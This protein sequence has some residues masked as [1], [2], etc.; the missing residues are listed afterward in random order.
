MDSCSTSHQNDPRIN[1]IW[2]LPASYCGYSV[3]MRMKGKISTILNPDVSLSHCFKI[4]DMGIRFYCFPWLILCLAMGNKP[5]QLPK[6]FLVTDWDYSSFGC[7]L[8]QGLWLFFPWGTTWLQ[9]LTLEQWFTSTKSCIF[10]L[11]A[12]SHLS[13]ARCFWLLS[14]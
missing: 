7:Y 14:F 12:A 11:P 4:K 2:N 6:A 9:S 10:C 3:E 1:F 8:T 13:H 5:S